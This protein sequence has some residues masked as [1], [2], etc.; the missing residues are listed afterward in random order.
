MTAEQP[1]ELLREYDG[2][3]L[4]RYPEHVLA[5]VTVDGPFEG[6]GN[7]AFRSLFKYISGANAPRGKIAMTAPVVQAEADPV[8]LTSEVSGDGTTK[9]RVAFVLPEHLS[10]DT[11]PAPT[12][13]AVTLRTV[14]ESVVVAVRFSGNWSEARYRRHLERLRADV[15]AAGLTVTEPPRS[16]RFDGPFVPSFLRHNEV[17][18]DVGVPL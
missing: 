14:P 5:E 3:E 12:D 8:A 18:F 7:R 15:A 17:Q 16:A 1:Y 11:A 13:P 2:F 6:A 4:R 9:Y 10:I